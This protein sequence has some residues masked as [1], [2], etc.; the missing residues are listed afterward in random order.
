MY[1]YPTY[2]DYLE[3]NAV[4]GSANL[5][6]AEFGIRSIESWDYSKNRPSQVVVFNDRQSM[7]AQSKGYD[8]GSIKTWEYEDYQ[9]QIIQEVFN[10]VD[11]IM[12]APYTPPFLNN[13]NHD[14]RVVIQYCIM[15]EILRNWNRAVAYP[16]TNMEAMLYKG[17][18]LIRSAFT[19]PF[20]KVLYDNLDYFL[21]SVPHFNMIGTAGYKLSETDTTN[22][23]G[24]EAGT[25]HNSTTGNVK[26]DS[27][28]TNVGTATSSN[29]NAGSDYPQSMVNLSM[30][31]PQQ[32][33][34]SYASTGSESL[35][36]DTTNTNTISI[37]TTDTTGSSDGGFNTDRS[38]MSTTV[39]ERAPK[40]ELDYEL[41]LFEF[42][43]RYAA[44]VWARLS[45]KFES[46]FMGLYVDDCRYHLI[47]IVHVN[48]YSLIV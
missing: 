5:T 11:L 35:G 27:D 4:E 38:G 1:F 2:I 18:P 36:K 47:D 22:Y 40:S 9:K 15:H 24:Q 33:D 14:Q 31:T 30:E 13:L 19:D 8:F 23:S 21:N 20:V 28:T 48:P 43:R 12:N 44:P 16:V 34:W 26:S 29:K 7:L 6:L 32:L 37:G 46:C 3:G 17:H 25:N 39:R 10:M 42:Y 41:E 45:D